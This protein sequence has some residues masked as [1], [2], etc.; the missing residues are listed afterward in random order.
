MEDAVEKDELIRCGFVWHGDGLQS[1]QFGFDEV[2]DRGDGWL[3][4]HFRC[5]ALLR[6]Q[7]LDVS[8][9]GSILWCY[10][11]QLL[12]LDGCGLLV[13]FEPAHR[14]QWAQHVEVF[15]QRYALG[16]QVA[17]IVGLGHAAV[18]VDALLAGVHRRH[19]VARQRGER[20]IFPVHDGR[21]DPLDEGG[22]GLPEQA[23]RLAQIPA[24]DV[25]VIDDVVF[26]DIAPC[27]ASAR[28]SRSRMSFRMRFGIM[29]ER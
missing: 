26:D 1:L 3:Q 27:S 25:D 8:M 29:R 20:A 4:A 5:G 18:V 13:T 23:Q 22:I 10:G 15:L 6:Q 24:V 9:Q 11:Q 19:R 17:A 28:R 7:C 21:L 12:E 14:E 2:V 16:T